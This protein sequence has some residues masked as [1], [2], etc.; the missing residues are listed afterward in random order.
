MK[1]I[2]SQFLDDLGKA[3]DAESRVAKALPQMV[4]PDTSTDLKQAILDHAE[5][6]TRHVYLLKQILKMFGHPLDRS[7][8]IPCTESDRELFET[9]TLPLDG[10]FHGRELSSYD[11]LHE[12]ANRLGNAEG[13]DFLE[14]VLAED[15]ATKRNDPQLVGWA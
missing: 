15:D 8:G 5:R 7:P 1:T 9:P 14:Q 10:P 11:S 4:K 3:Y 6:T 13:A 2:S 12:W